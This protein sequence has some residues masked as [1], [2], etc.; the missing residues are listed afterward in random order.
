MRMTVV[1]EPDNR[2]NK[3]DRDSDFCKG[4]VERW[5]FGGIHLRLDLRL[6]IGQEAITIGQ[7]EGGRPA[8]SRNQILGTICLFA[9]IKNTT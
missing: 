2:Q 3:G 8:S 6:K 9:R 4:S 7:E 1:A 5:A